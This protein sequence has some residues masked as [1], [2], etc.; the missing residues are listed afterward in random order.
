MRISDSEQ[1]QTNYK[2]LLYFN[3]AV[4]VLIL[5]LLIVIDLVVVH[6]FWR[7]LDNSDMNNA[8]V[9]WYQFI[10]THGRIRALGM[11]F[12]DYAPPFLYLL[13]LGTLANCLRFSPASVIRGISVA[14]DVVAF[15]PVYWFAKAGGRASERSVFIALSFIALPE[16][17]VNSLVWGQ[18][19]IIYTMF[20]IAFVYFAMKERGMSATTMLGLAFSFKLQTIFIGPFVLYLLVVGLLR[21][22][23]LLML[24]LTYVIMLIPSAL[25]GR[26]WGNLLFIYKRQTGEFHQLSLNAPNLYSVIQK[27]LPN[28]FH[29]LFRISLVLA[30]IVAL[31]LVGAFVRR[32]RRCSPEGLVLMA[33]LSL[34]VMPYVLPEM[35]ERYFFAAGAMAFLL[36]V[37]RPRTWPI[38]LLIQSANL[39]AYSRF[40][41]NASNYWL[42]CGVVLMTSAIGLLLWQFFFGDYSLSP[43]LY[44]VHSIA[45]KLEKVNV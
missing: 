45:Q 28:S 38:A 9:P 26:R 25:A 11:D 8:F 29:A 3:R 41:L 30:I 37:M 12:A 21:W 24:P 31:I 4:P 43:E 1:D 10:V 27:V 35:H 14:C 33:T 42:L 2:L 13:S 15:V 32:G 6:I 19:D 16:M 5:L 44:K 34:A 39:C 40:L 20:L 17:V 7:K 18:C 22:R 23:H 36:S